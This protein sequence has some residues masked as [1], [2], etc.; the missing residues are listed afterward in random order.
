M[1]S[2]G[3]RENEGNAVSHARPTHESGLNANGDLHVAA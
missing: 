1:V 3:Q 2:I